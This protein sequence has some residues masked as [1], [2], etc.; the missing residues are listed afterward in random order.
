MGKDERRNETID[1]GDVADETSAGSSRLGK[2]AKIGVAVIGTLVVIL[3]IVATVRMMGAGPDEPI[4]AAPPDTPGHNDKKIDV[5]PKERHS[6]PFGSDVLPTVVPAN[7]AS[8][9][10]PKTIT[11]ESNRWKLTAD[12]REAKRTSGAS[13]GAPPEFAS[14]TPKPPK[15]DRHDPY[16]LDSLPDKPRDTLALPHR[17]HEDLRSVTPDDVPPARPN[18]WGSASTDDSSGFSM[19]EPSPPAPSPR[20]TSRYA[21]S[22]APQPHTRYA[23]TPDRSTPAMPVGQYDAGF[24]HDSSSGRAHFNVEPHHMAPSSLYNNPPPQR[25]DGKYEVQPNDSYWTISEKLYG[26]G[27]YFKALAQRNRDQNANEDQLQPGSL[28]LAPPVAELEK[29]YPDLCPKPERREAMQTQGRNRNSTV[30]TRGMYRGG[31]TYTVAEGDTLFNI[32]RYELGKASRWAEIYDL[33]RDVLGK[34]FNYLA[35]GTQLVL[36][37][38]ER[39]DVI[40]QPPRETRLR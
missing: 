27:S 12:R 4:A 38:S 1:A 13:L 14:D 21:M 11:S 33:N 40:A 10:P 30:G 29:S 20:E 6:K 3:G 2:E 37:D 8:S 7:A 24:R 31:R 17:K 26:T 22:S 32:A 18:R 36:P 9:K 28:I 15:A 5:L 19:A 34:D 16:A 39:S 25:D 23:A 35:P